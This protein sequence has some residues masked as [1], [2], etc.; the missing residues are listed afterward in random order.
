MKAPIL[1]LAVATAAFAGSSIYLWQQ[2]NDE[3]A[4][5]A[6]VEETARKL[7]ARVAELEKARVE[8]AERRMPGGFMAGHFATNGSP[9]PPPPA[10]QSDEKTSDGPDKALWTAMRREPSPAMKKMMQS[11]F[12]ANN[13]RLYA[14]VG[15]KLGLSKDTAT[16]LIDLLSE[17]TVAR[18]DALRTA[19]NPDEASRRS[20]KLDQEND[21]AISDLIGP[22]KALSLKEY[23]ESMPARMEVQGLAHQLESNDVPLTA[24]QRQKLTD[25]Y[26]TE[27]ARV[28]QP[29]YSDGE[30]DGEYQKAYS[31]WRDDYEKRIASEAGQVLNTDQLN[32]YNEIQ[33]WQKE[34]RE[35]PL[36]LPPG[37][38]P[39]RGPGPTNM[40]FSTGAAMGAVAIT[41]VAPPQPPPQKKP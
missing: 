36:Q 4:R 40:F 18:M 33:Q 22:D 17:Q 39:P 15:S 19:D 5:A 38:R 20:A 28:P 41:T 37:F 35:Q 12:R 6:Q 25:I 26:V 3:R 7:N 30:D 9:P 24:E 14:D 31:A 23:Q 2:L 34:M 13:K 32:A 16:K 29:E 1:G 27:R 8:F 21:Q 11:Q 10:G